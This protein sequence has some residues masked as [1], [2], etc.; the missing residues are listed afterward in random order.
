MRSRRSGS[1]DAS[2]RETHAEP[3]VLLVAEALLDGE[4]LAVQGDDLRAG[5]VGVAGGQ[6]PGVFHP[7][8]LH[9][10]DRA[11]LAVG[12]GDL[13]AAQAQWSSVLR[14]PVLGRLR[15]AVGA[16]DLHDAAEAHDEVQ[17]ELVLEDLAE[18]LVAEASVG[19]HRHVHART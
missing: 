9:A 1:A 10:H 11:D 15:L 16:R 8:G 18:G 19:E 13:G 6:V 12:P 2:V 5:L 17:T 3:E 4:P 14:N 7:L